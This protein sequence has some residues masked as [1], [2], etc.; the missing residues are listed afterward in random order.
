MQIWPGAM[1]MLS[2]A[3]IGIIII[4]ILSELMNRT[5]KDPEMKPYYKTMFTRS[6]IVMVFTGT[7]YVLP[8][9]DLIKLYHRDD[10]EYARLFILAHEHPENVEYKKAFEEYKLKKQE[11]D[12][13]DSQE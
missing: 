1:G 5:T 3:N 12:F 9:A 7:L 11:A 10:P 6:I 2:M 13:K 4:L 8:T